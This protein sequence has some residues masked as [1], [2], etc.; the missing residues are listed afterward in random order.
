M[1]HVEKGIVHYFI[2]T[3]KQIDNPVAFQ[4]PVWW[5]CGILTLDMVATTT[6]STASLLVNV[7][8]WFLLV[9]FEQLFQGISGTCFYI[10]DSFV[11][12]QPTLNSVKALTANQWPGFSLGDRL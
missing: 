4:K 11:V 3:N 5:I 7:V 12:T 2:V 1:F 8:S 10:P 6:V 9:F